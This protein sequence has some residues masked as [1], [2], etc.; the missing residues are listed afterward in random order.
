MDV[1]ADRI[2]FWF[3]GNMLRHAEIGLAEL[4]N[5]N[6]KNGAVTFAAWSPGRF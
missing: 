2:T 4:R 1:N 6:L 3:G 5:T